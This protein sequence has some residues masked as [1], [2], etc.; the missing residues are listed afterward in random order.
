MV[1]G[2]E[3]VRVASW[4]D[5]RLEVDP[6]DPRDGW[7][8]LLCDIAR[9]A[10]VCVHDADGALVWATQCTAE[11]EGARLAEARA[12]FDVVAPVV[13]SGALQVRVGHREMPG[14]T[15]RSLRDP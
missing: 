8:R 9:G 1:V 12:I 6:T 7:T 11:D 5:G 2:Y 10:R 14:G 3:E 15:F 13:A 4:S